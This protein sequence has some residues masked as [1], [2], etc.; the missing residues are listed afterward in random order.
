M[1]F[2]T[3]LDFLNTFLSVLFMCD[4]SIEGYLSTGRCETGWGWGLRSCHFSLLSCNG[5]VFQWFCTHKNDTQT[6]KHVRAHKSSLNSCSDVFFVLCFFSFNKPRCD[7][8]MPKFANSH[9][10]TA[11]SLHQSSVC[12]INAAREAFSVYLLHPLKYLSEFVRA[13]RRRHGDSESEF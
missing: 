1:F 11:R 7:R 10:L 2:L 8:C 12:E 6:H 4:F 9:M 13:L 3:F 5:S